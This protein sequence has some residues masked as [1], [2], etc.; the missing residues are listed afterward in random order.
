MLRTPTG[1]RKNGN[2]D[3]VPST[4]TERS[5]TV[6]PDSMRGRSRL[7][8]ERLSIGAYRRLA[9]ST[10][11][12]VAE[13]ARLE[14][15]RRQRLPF[16]GADGPGRLARDVDLVLELATVEMHLPSGRSYH[17]ASNGASCG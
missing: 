17:P 9:S 7:P 2:G 15:L 5:R 10:A 13:G 16:V 6:L 14:L 4:S 1:A 12:D 3:G 8:L 11:R